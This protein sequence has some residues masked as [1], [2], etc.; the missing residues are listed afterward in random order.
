[1]VNK[2]EFMELLCLNSKDKVKKFLISN[3]KGPKPKCPIIFD[4]KDETS[5]S[6]K[7]KQEK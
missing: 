7:E 3:G 1:M 5:D 4:M 6:E 2:N